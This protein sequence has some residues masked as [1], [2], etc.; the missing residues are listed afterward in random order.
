MNAG[1]LV[2]RSPPL[3]SLLPSSHRLVVFVASKEVRL[4]IVRLFNTVLFLQHD[5]MVMRSFSSRTEAVACL[6]DPIF[7][8]WG[9]SLPV[10]GAGKHVT[11]HVPREDSDP[12]CVDPPPVQV[13]VSAEV[14]ACAAG[15]PQPPAPS[16][17]TFSS[18]GMEEASCL[19]SGAV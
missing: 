18:R 19:I 4:D 6:R 9:G 14:E 12:L 17:A 3:I 5:A 11:I 8:R 15:L 16:F 10:A 1:S 2:Q 7:S 13:R